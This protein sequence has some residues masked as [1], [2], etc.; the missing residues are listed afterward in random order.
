[1]LHVGE[2]IYGIV[3]QVP[4]VMHVGTRMLHFN[5]LP[6]FPLGTVVVVE[7]GVVG[8]K[9]VLKT[10]F[11]T[12][13][14]AYAFVRLALLWGAL[15]LLMVGVVAFDLQK[16]A[17]RGNPP[18]WFQSLPFWMLASSGLSF[19]AW[20]LSHRW[21]YASYQRAIQW[22]DLIGLDREIVDDNFRRRGLTIGD[23]P[24]AVVPVLAAEEKDDVYRLE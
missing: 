8:E 6:C 2:H 3:D 23:E 10:R 7:K 21:T 1:M 4:G 9:T 18:P 19:L 15:V 24:L 5:F 22:A 13:S 20:W 11:S 12:R 16:A 14:V 17:I